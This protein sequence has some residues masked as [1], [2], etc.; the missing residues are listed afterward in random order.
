VAW[1]RPAGASSLG[2]ARSMA[3]VQPVAPASANPGSATP[4]AAAIWQPGGAAG[5]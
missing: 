3:A 2:M 1:A 5:R 4:V